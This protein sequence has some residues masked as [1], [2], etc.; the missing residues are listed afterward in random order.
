MRRT[1]VPDSPK[2]GKKSEREAA[3]LRHTS[4]PVAYPQI[5]LDIATDRGIDPRAVLRGTPLSPEHL[6]DP[7]GRVPSAAAA[8]MVCNAIELTGDAALGIEFGLRLRPTSQGFLGYAA[9]A[10]ATLGE[11]LTLFMRYG[12]VRA[13]DVKLVVSEQGERS[14]LRFAE[15]HGLG[16]WRRVFYECLMVGLARV[17]GLLLGEEMLDC[18]LWFEWAEADYIERYRAR[19][20][21]LRFGMPQNQVAMKSAL[22]L[23]PLPGADAGAARLAMAQVRRELALTLRAPEHLGERV[24]AEL[25]LGVDGYPD[26]ETIAARLFLST[27]TLKRRLQA[28]GTGYQDLLDEARRRDAMRLLENPDLSLQQIAYALGYADPPSFTRAFRR[29]TGRAPSAARSG[30]E[31]ERS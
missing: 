29:W 2:S 7:E 12:D 30:A 16:P 24:R 26:L 25:S 1:R 19:L 14:L 28:C 4:L 11:A 23:R 3:Q 10:S 5:V 20:P 13:R 31:G 27:R 8:R 6:L 9:M 22:L 18:E 15:T 21:A 17:A